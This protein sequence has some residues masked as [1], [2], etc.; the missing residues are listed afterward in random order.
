MWLLFCLL[1]LKI[2]LSEPALVIDS[3]HMVTTQFVPTFAYSRVRCGHPSSLQH[4]RL[5]TYFLGLGLGSKDSLY[6]WYSASESVCLGSL[7][8]WLK[9]KLFLTPWDH[10]QGSWGAVRLDERLKNQS[11]TMDRLGRSRLG[12]SY[13]FGLVL[14]PEILLNRASLVVRT[15]D[16]VR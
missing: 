16:K 4:V 7:L 1:L 15:M 8:L 2:V 3:Q 13:E 11:P 10:C 5:K 6:G 12:T 9:S 14:R